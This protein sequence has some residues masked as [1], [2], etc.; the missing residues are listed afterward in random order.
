[1]TRSSTPKIAC[2][3]WLVG[4]VEQ[5]ETELSERFL[6][7]KQNK[8]AKDDRGRRPGQVWLLLLATDRSSRMRKHSPADGKAQ[9]ITHS[10]N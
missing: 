3:R 10:Q 6:F 7:K 4:K 2:D 5:E 9:F 8:S 1:M